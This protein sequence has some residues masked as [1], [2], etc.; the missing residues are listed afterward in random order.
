M[1]ERILRGDAETKLVTQSRDL[2]CSPAG[3]A[4]RT[5]VRTK[6]T[7][8][9]FQSQ[10]ALLAELA[11]VGETGVGESPRGLCLISAAKGT[12]HP[13]GD[14]TPRFPSTDSLRSGAPDAVGTSLSA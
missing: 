13:L 9:S 4:I 2:P 12:C 10:A 3:T 5:F 1:P 8:S 7:P 14:E 6:Y 11:E